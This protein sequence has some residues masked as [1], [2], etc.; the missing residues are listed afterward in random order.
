MTQ[1]TVKTAAQIRREFIEYFTQ[2]HAHAFVPSSPVVPLD[3]PTL[4]FTNAGM[5]QFKDVFL[6]TG[7]RDYRRAANTQKCIRAGGKHNDLEDVGKDTYHHTFFEMLGNWSF[8]DYFK[9]EAIEWAW[10]LLVNQWGLDPDRL[11]ATVFAGEPSEGTE[12]DV[13]AEDLWKRFLPAERISRWGKK[14]NFWEMGDSGPCGP[15]SEIHYDDRPDELRREIPGSQLVN[16]DDPNVIEIWNLVFIQYN[17][18]PGTDGRPGPLSLLP[19]KHVDTGM[20]FERLV[21]VIQG[22]Q[23]NYDI[24]HW[25]GIFDAIGKM[26]GVRPYARDMDDPID[27][28]Y[29]VL[30]DHARCLTVAITDGAPPSN[31]GRGYVLRRIL[32][33]GVR[34][35]RQTMGVEK[36]MLCD[37]VPAVVDSLGDAF[38]ELRSSAERV[39][40][41]IRDEEEAFLRTL[42]RGLVLFSEAAVRGLMNGVMKSERWTIEPTY[43]RSAFQVTIRDADHAVVASDSIDSIRPMWTSEYFATV[44]RISADDSFRLHDTYGFPI[45]LTRLMAQERGMAVDEDGFETLMAE[46]REASR[47]G[48]ET[49]STVALTPEAVATLQERRIAPTH[50][51]DKYHGRAVVAQVKAIWTGTQFVDRATPGDDVGVV[52]SQTNHYAEQG[53]QVGDRGSIVA[54]HTESSTPTGTFAVRDAQVLGGYVAHLGAVTDG[55][56]AVGDRVTVRLD[57]VH[58]TPIRANHT[59]THLLNLALRDVLGDDVHQKGSLVAP[60][61]LRFDF[62]CSHAITPEQVARIEQQVNRDIGRALAVHADIVPLNKAKEITGLR[63]VFGERYPDPVR[64]VSIGP[65]VSALLAEPTNEDWRNYSIEFCG[66]THLDGTEAAGHFVIVQEGALAAGVRRITAL[67]GSLAREAED[68][69][70]AL[71]TRMLDAEQLSV[72]ELGS[73][74]DELAKAVDEQ[75]M[76]LVARH[77]LRT[78]LE[79]LREQVNHSRK[80]AAESAKAVVVDQARSLAENA[81]GEVIVSCLL[82]ADKD[83]LPAAMDVINAKQPDAAVMLFAGDEVE[84]KVTILATVPKAMIQRGLKAGDWVKQAAQVC[85]GGGGGRPDRAQ[86]GGKDPSKITEAIAASE[87]FAHTKLG[88]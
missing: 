63:A 66:G 73:E 72:R 57:A 54:D 76:S 58:R 83:S 7:T 22:K 88:D 29:R 41:I 62:S 25:Q 87:T 82:G 48:G 84:Q 28:A 53:G 67:T 61:R 43:E 44:P 30:A 5:N 11:Y 18:A 56:L 19:A 21:R 52:L 15:C 40:G 39:A 31:E 77:T 12:P 34:I 55:A 6:G 35:A 71:E 24:D 60:D 27:I 49:E 13:E 85:G 50:D 74:I 46:A 37:L 33:R 17:R 65:E 78:R 1:T 47:Q 80:M 68:A 36:P 16:A 38:P 14:D 2:K 45:D 69:A 81:Q 79:P 23:S 86:A 59:A 26:S 64:V 8:G 9:A 3:D 70:R 42:D 32:R 4:L 20:G 75:T 51:I 10:D